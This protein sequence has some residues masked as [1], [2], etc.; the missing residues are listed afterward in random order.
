MTTFRE[1]FFGCRFQREKIE[2]RG[3]GK[4]PRAA[5]AKDLPLPPPEAPMQIAR[6]RVQPKRQDPRDATRF[7]LAQQLEHFVPAVAL[8]VMAA[9]Q[10]QLAEL[11][12]CAASLRQAARD[13]PPAHAL[14]PAE[15]AEAVIS[16]L[17][18]RFE[19]LDHRVAASA[20]I[21][22]AGAASETQASDGQALPQEMVSELVQVLTGPLESSIEEALRPR[23]QELEQ[24][25]N[26]ARLQ[27]R[28]PRISTDIER[29]PTKEEREPTTE[30]EEPQ[31]PSQTLKRSE[32]GLSFASTVSTL[33]R[34]KRQTSR[35]KNMLPPRAF[36]VNFRRLVDVQK[37][38]E[39]IHEFIRSTAIA[40]LTLV[41]ASNWSQLAVSVIFVTLVLVLFAVHEM[42]HDGMD[43]EDYKSLVDLLEDD[44]GK[45]QGRVIE[46]PNRLLKGLSLSKQKSRRR[47][48]FVITFFAVVVCSLVWIN[49]CWSWLAAPDDGLWL[50]LFDEEDR[51]VQASLLLVG[52]AMVLFHMSYEWLYWRET[53]CVM[54]FKDGPNGGQA[55]DPREHS[56]GVPSRYRWFG[57]PSMWFTSR[58]AYDDLRLWITLCHED[59]EDVVVKIRPEEMA[60]LALNPDGASYLRKTL[61][62]AKLFRMS[63]WEFLTRDAQT[64]E[65]RPVKGEDPEE[66]GIEFVLFD[67]ASELFLQPEVDYR[68]GMMRLLTRS[69]SQLLT[70]SRCPGHADLLT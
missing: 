5:A 41:A 50:G 68:S 61:R 70:P 60:L 42:R 36:V 44:T 11:D 16:A 14:D 28:Q 27:W 17:S 34:V 29:E 18:S 1:E 8:S 65:L 46:N 62:H 26:Q 58:Q 35:S 63:T 53:Q 10:P 43:I 2:R 9:V 37:V 47:S 66:L 31:L 51:N 6:P 32:K 19:E 21:A 52:T 3:S 39:I 54:P 55:F 15:V 49:I 24:R 56:H 57:L 4:K 22:A 38:L 67:R 13:T 25:L 45:C 12:A 59:N 40:T 69:F 20:A 30:E 48:A 23:L 33:G 7:L 64:G